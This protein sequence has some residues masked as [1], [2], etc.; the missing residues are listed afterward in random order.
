VED[1]APEL[2]DLFDELVRRTRELAGQE[3]PA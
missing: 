2:V 3:A 1:A